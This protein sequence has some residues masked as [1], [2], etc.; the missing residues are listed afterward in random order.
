LESSIA[1]LHAMVE[2]YGKGGKAHLIG[3]S[4]GAMLAAVYAG[5]YPGRVDHL[6]LAEPGFLTPDRAKVFLQ[7][8]KPSLSL[9]S[10]TFM[11]RTWFESLHV[12]GPDAY[13]QKDF[14]MGRFMTAYDGT[15]HPL[16]GYFCEEKQSEESRRAWRFGYGA[17]ESILRS[18][19]DGSGTFTADFTV[20]LE[21]IKGKV[22]F[23]SGECNTV[24]GRDQQIRNMTHF[25]WAELVVIKGAGHYMLSE[26][27]RESM[28]V[29][30][31]Y[32][33]QRL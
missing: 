23:L 22:L 14:I 10:M 5:R 29:I 8:T 6:V 32:L 27:P 15:D 1:D 17:M 28:A 2:Y 19:M 7:R 25:P 31:Q 18:G 24:T 13:A 20:G 26:N 12:K 11:V 21:K 4:W 16:R 9:S 30:R 3:H 33:D